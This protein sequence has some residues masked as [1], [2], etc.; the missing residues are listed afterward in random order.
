MET[1][2]IFLLVIAACGWIWGIVQFFLNKKIQRHDKITDRK[3]EAYQ[4]FMSKFDQLNESMRLDNKK[5]FDLSSLFLK[6]ILIDKVDP[7]IA[8][9]DFNEELKGYMIKSLEPLQIL[10]AELNRIYLVGSKTVIKKIEEFQNL[11]KNLQEEFSSI[12]ENMSFSNP[13]D[14]SEKIKSMGNDERMNRFENLRRE[15]I[16]LMREEVAQ[17]KK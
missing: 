3:F 17:D 7:S 15:I 1:K 12:L 11:A 9:I 14:L 10:S 4:I 2:D 8:L 16:I 13:N 5:V 6:K